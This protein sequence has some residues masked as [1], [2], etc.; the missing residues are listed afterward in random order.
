MPMCQLKTLF[1]QGH[2]ALLAV[3]QRNSTA[4]TVQ[5]FYLFYDIVFQTQ[6][7]YD[8]TS[9]K[10]NRFHIQDTVHLR[11]G[12]TVYVAEKYLLLDLGSDAKP[13][14]ISCTKPTKNQVYFFSY[15]NAHL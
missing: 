12:A 4:V 7:E 9:G 15:R 14:T 8:H 11:C 13:L 3:T 5:Q 6:D 10:H 1:P 2:G